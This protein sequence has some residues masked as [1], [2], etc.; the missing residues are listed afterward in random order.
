MNKKLAGALANIRIDAA[1]LEP[2]DNEKLIKVGVAL[3]EAI[4]GDDDAS[5]VSGLLMLCLQ[6]LQA[7]YT[8]E[9]GSFA[10]VAD[11]LNNALVAAEQA[12]A[13]PANKV[14]EALLSNA[15]ESLSR[16]LGIEPASSPEAEETSEQ[17]R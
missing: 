12:A 7:L 1:S 15:S 17:P 11:A 8:G 4:P 14:S 10:S 9:N 16:A 13:A 5:G 6:A 2:G 3:E